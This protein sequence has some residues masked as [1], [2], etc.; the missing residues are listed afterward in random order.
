MANKAPVHV[1]VRETG[2][3]VVREG[4][5]QATSIHPTQNEAAKEGRDIARQDE[6]EFYLHAQDGRVREHRSYGEGSPLEDEAV[7]DQTSQMADAAGGETDRDR[8]EGIAD[9]RSDDGTPGE[10]TYDAEEARGLTDAGHEYGI[11]TPDERYAG[12][13]V[14]DRDGERIGRPDDLFV[15]EDDIPEYVGIRMGSSGANSVLVPAAVVTV[16][17]SLKRIVV[18]RP[19][20]IVESGPRLGHAE[21]LTPELEQ[22]V[23][24]YYGLPSLRDVEVRSGYGAYFGSDAE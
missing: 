14:Y 1:E 20:S 15:D 3:A 23:R 21:Q 4:S 6:T 24:D 12:Y 18:S 19:R 10:E 8:S 9:L 17:D 11:A 22:Q 5:G 7:A 13:E 2:W 16:V